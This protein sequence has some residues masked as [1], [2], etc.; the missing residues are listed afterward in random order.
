MSLVWY[1]GAIFP[2]II[3][4]HDNLISFKNGIVNNLL[5]KI[6]KLIPDENKKAISYNDGSVYLECETLPNIINT[7]I[8]FRD[9]SL[10]ANEDI[11][12]FLFGYIEIHSSFTPDFSQLS[13]NNISSNLFES[14]LKLTNVKGEYKSDIGLIS[15]INVLDFLSY[16]FPLSQCT[17]VSNTGY[18]LYE[19]Y[20]SLAYGSG[21]FQRVLSWT[22]KLPNAVA[23]FK[24]SF[25]DVGWDLTLI[26]KAKE[27][28][29]KT[30]LYDT[31]ISVEPPI[32]F[33][34][35]IYPRSSL[36]KSGYVL[37]NSK[38][39]IDPAYT[40]N[41]LVALTKVDEKSK[42]IELPFVAVQM[43]LEPVSY[44]L[45]NETEKICDTSRGS[46]GFGST[47]VSETNVSSSVSEPSVSS[48]DKKANV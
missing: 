1:A 48:D 7:Y 20:H 42:D 19:I 39:I 43:V 22:R 12:T 25:S 4:I 40:G 11:K 21:S 31:G 46:G 29:S 47:S 33:Y 32:G 36:S 15:G 41:I 16:F 30:T 8:S 37:S 44:A 10:I 17:I 24:A 38:G 5:D 45:L 26:T 14:I 2:E 6:M 34:V 18:T 23:P 3:S 35:A 13:L 28:N 27:L 9:K